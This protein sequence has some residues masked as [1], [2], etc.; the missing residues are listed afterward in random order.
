MSNPT[1]AWFYNKQTQD[2]TVNLGL[3]CKFNN[4]QSVYL[5]RQGKFNIFTPSIE[6]VAGH[7]PGPPV[8]HI[9]RYWYQPMI[10]IGMTDT[11][12]SS[13]VYDLMAFHGYITSSLKFPGEGIATQLINRDAS[14]DGIPFDSTGGSYCLDGGETYPDSHTDVS[15]TASRNQ[16]FGDIDYADGPGI[17][18]QYASWASINDHFKTYCRFRPSGA[19]SIYVTLRRV[20]WDWHATVEY[21]GYNPFDLSSWTITS[22]GIGGPTP[23]DTNEF[24]Q[25]DCTQ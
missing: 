21:T 24:P 8:F 18:I 20:D 1:P 14:I 5:V 25:W 7:D 17:G 9:D 6:V 16:C 2:A 11:N 10:R 15:E 23:M 4:G 13:N 22:S 19:D 12:N 3:Y